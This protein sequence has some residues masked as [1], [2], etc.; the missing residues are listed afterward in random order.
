MNSVGADI[1]VR[2]HVQG[3]GYRYFCMTRAAN[4]ELTGWVKNIPDQSVVA[5]VEGSRGGIE[6]FINDL[7]QGPRAA[8]VTSVDVRWTAYTGKFSTF[9]VTG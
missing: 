3:V 4:L 6:I 2:G 9:S 8:A 1:T 7:K 5:H